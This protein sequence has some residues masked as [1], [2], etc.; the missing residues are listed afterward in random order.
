MREDSVT[1]P[2]ALQ[3]INILF[4]LA[5]E[6]AVRE[7]ERAQRYARLLYKISSHYRVGLAKEI[8]N[9][10]CSRCYRVFV[11]GLN[12]SVKVVSANRF[13]LYKCVCGKE[14]HIRY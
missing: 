14:A 13:V 12:C 5:K 8:Q 1:R 10:I 3:R 7:Q 9:S 11:P 2:I 6:N 4:N